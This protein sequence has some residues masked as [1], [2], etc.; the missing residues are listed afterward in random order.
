MVTQKQYIVGFNTSPFAK[1]FKELGMC[2]PR[3][4]KIN[5]GL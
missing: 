2:S 4:I 3:P 5:G 1:C